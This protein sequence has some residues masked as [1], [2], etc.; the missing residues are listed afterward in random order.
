MGDAGFTFRPSFVFHAKHSGR[1]GLDNFDE[2]STDLCWKNG[3]QELTIN[4]HSIRK[5][6]TT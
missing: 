2:V 3:F 4:E 1:I 6:Q 5:N